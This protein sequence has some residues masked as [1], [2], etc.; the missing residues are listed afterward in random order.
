M[1]GIV[2]IIAETSQNVVSSVLESLKKLEYRG[3]DSAGIAIFNNQDCLK[4][5]KTVGKVDDLIAKEQNYNYCGNIALAH[6]RWATHGKP[7]ENNAHPH[8]SNNQI[9]VVHNGIIENFAQLKQS[10]LSDGYLF[11]SD[12]DTEVVA[13]LIH[14][15]LQKS[16]DFLLAVHQA[17][18]FLEGS[19][20][21]LVFNAQDPNKLIAIRHGSPLVVGLGQGANYLSSDLVS[22]LDKTNKFIHLLE[23]DICVIDAQSVV[24]FDNNLRY[25]NREVTVSQ[26][27][28]DATQKDGYQHYMQKEIYEQP[29]TIKNTL[30]HF[31]YDKATAEYIKNLASKINKIQI[32][33]CGSSYHAG[34]VAKYWCESIAKI[35]CEVDIGSEF[36]YRSAFV[37]PGTLFVTISQSGETADT[38][39]GL[40][41]AKTQ[42]YLGYLT[43]CNVPESSLAKE[44]EIAFMTQAGVEIG[45][46]TTK[47]FSAQ[48]L[49]LLLL[50]LLCGQEKNTLEQSFTS[51]YDELHVLPMF[52]EQILQLDNNMLRL[53]K[54]FV[55]KNHAFYLGRGTMFPIALEGALKL[56]EISYIHAE[57]YPAGELKH[58]PL[59][60]IDNNMPVIVLAPHN[61]LWDKINAN[62]HEVIA[63]DGEMF[64]F[65]DFNNFTAN[66]KHFMRKAKI[67]Q[68]PKVPELLAPL[69]YVVALQL[70]SYHIATLRGENVDQ[71]R[72]LAKSVTVE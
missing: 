62:I 66:E 10:L 63:R 28:A 20:A 59:A 39:A 50:I 4:V 9:T 3:Y 36:R 48:L 47:A 19:F 29:Q 57:A 8:I 22:L 40:R 24:I 1:C 42:D 53:A 12:T 18:Q 61:S 16:K 2:G 69:V 56:K 58:G 25:V 52:I 26:L 5:I 21:L 45:V 7:T 31:S 14:K 27:T 32:V 13:H 70:L 51:Y 15:Q 33:A 55:N 6:T 67:I 11:T 54:D 34:L 72:N 64:I 38:L 71:P 65:T 43:I 68:M 23:D 60:L 44:S 46:A 37:T 41:L 17:I 49:N 30:L 35:A